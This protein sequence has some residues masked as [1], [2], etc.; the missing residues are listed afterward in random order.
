MK[1]KPCVIGLIVVCLAA[2]LRAVPDQPAPVKDHVL[3]VGSDFGVVRKGV[4]EPVIAAG[5]RTFVISEG[6]KR[7][8]LALRDLRDIRLHRGLKMTNLTASID[9]VQAVLSSDA[10]NA[11]QMEATLNTMALAM[12]EDMNRDRA[13]G[14]MHDQDVGRGAVGSTRNRFNA[15]VIPEAEAKQLVA[16]NNYVQAESL[17]TQ[18]SYFLHDQIDTHGAAVTN[19]GDEVEITADVSA[20]SAALSVTGQQ[21][22]R[23]ASNPSEASKPKTPPI[24][25]A[26]GGRSDHLDLSF[27]ISAPRPLEGTYAVITTEY[28]APNATEVFRRILTQRLGRIDA[29]PK[30]VSLYETD[31]PQGF[32]L[33]TYVIGVYAN[34]Q[35]VATNLSESRISMTRD[36]AYEYIVADYLASHKGQSLPPAAVLMAPRSELAAA[37]RGPAPDQPVYVSVD[38][39]GTVTNISTVP[40]KDRTPDGALRAAL[41]NFRFIP[42]LQKG[43][44]VRGRAKLVVSEFVQD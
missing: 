38:E 20:G 37:F 15:A 39:S 33:R 30:K 10:A 25:D 5:N 34:G 21:P 42:A 29:R 17:R 35:E 11:E 8:E 28:T 13:Y 24:L 18:H 4:E 31:Y 36:E 2:V 6:G 41:Q 44:P 9:K 19:D 7:H 26:G 23:P 27:V 12:T 40:G 1:T 43:V 14:Q 3:F 22:V 32:H 16:N